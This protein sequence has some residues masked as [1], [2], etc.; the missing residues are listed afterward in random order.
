MDID[1]RLLIK[2]DADPM[3]RA[4]GTLSHVIE[5]TYGE[6]IRGML[7]PP[8]GWVPTPPP[9]G[10]HARLVRWERRH[11]DR[12][13]RRARVKVANVIGGPRL[14]DECGDW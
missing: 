2:A 10:W 6:A 8:P 13:A 11:I 3:T 1:R 14:H 12:P 7:R 9:R 5:T 4:M